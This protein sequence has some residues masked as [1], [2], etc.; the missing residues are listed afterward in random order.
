[1][2]PEG[3][4]KTIWGKEQI[5]WFMNTIENS[6]A[7]FKILISPTPIV[8]PD[9][10]KGKLDNHSNTSFKTEGKWLRKYLADHNV[11]VVNGDRHWQYVSVDSETGLREFSQG[12]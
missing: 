3:I 6:D 11:F 9:R 5:A 4:D 8:G 1:M 12:Q 7:T 10:T 2:M